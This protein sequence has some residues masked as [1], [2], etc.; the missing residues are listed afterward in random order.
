MEDLA[1]KEPDISLRSWQRSK[2]KIKGEENIG[3]TETE[4]RLQMNKKCHYITAKC[5]NKQLYIT[6]PYECKKLGYVSA[7]VGQ[8]KKAGFMTKHFKKI[9]DAIAFL[10]ESFLSY[11]K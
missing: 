2:T 9:D 10:P 7:A 3:L 8:T 4:T 11:S 6:L 5:K 1:V